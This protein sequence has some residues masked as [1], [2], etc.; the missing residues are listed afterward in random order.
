MD[1]KDQQ[2]PDNVE[3]K[4]ASQ[5]QDSQ[6]KPEAQPDKVDKEEIQNQ[7]SNQYYIMTTNDQQWADKH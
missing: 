1:P 3:A 7:N 6:Q 4:E 2:P 5:A